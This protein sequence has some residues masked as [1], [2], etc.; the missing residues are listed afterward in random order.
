MARTKVVVNTKSFEKAFMGV[1][2][3]V[4]R[5]IQNSLGEELVKKMKDLVSK[6]ISPI[7][8]HGRFPAYKSSTKEK[9]RYPDTVKGKFPSKR[10][11]PV[12]LGL[13]GQFLNHLS[14]ILDFAQDKFGI[15]LGFFDE[16]SIQKEKGHREQANGQ[17]FRPIIPKGKEKLSKAVYMEAMR[18]IKSAI[19]K[20][21]GK[22]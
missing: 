13:T 6:G 5:E 2:E 18:I 21:Y 14:Y 7:E 19:K 9:K 15:R 10:R 16:E 22:F 3:E 1:R 11:R 20:Y 8:G 17:A 12:N 4:K